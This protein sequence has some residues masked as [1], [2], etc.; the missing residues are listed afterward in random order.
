ML[1]F[2][3]VI[4]VVSR[5]QKYRKWIPAMMIIFMVLYLG[6]VAPAVNKS[7]SVK[8]NDSYGKIMTGLQSSSPFYTGEPLLLSMQ[9]QLDQLMGRLFEMPPVTGFMV[10]EVRRS[11]FQMGN[12]MKTLYY[13]FIPRIVWP[14]KPLVSRG[15]WFT[16]YLRMAP[17]EAE[18]TTSTG[19][20]TVGEWYWNFG[21]AGVIGGMFLTG[22]L[23]SGLWRIAGSYP[24]HQP[25]NMVLYVGLITNVFSLPDATSPIVSSIAL[26]LLFGSLIYLSKSRQ[27]MATPARLPNMRPLVMNPANYS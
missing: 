11:G 2:L 26:Y 1:A 24:I 10:N 3:P 15:A 17:R 23:L 21:V 8:S 7:R 4:V 9:G 20:T 19:M 27:K 18:A 6:V 13:A 22:L 25:A 5:H 12:T 14:V 16:T